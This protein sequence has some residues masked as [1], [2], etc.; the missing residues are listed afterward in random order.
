VTVG[1]RLVS[2]LRAS[3]IAS[4]NAVGGIEEQTSCPVLSWAASGA[5]W[6]TGWPDGPPQWPA[7]DVIGALGGTTALLG[8]LAGAFGGD[9]GALD[10]GA[11][12]TGRAAVR[13][14]ARRG[15]TSV[16][17]RSRILRAS[18]GWV[19][20]TLSRPCDLELLPALSAGEIPAEHV[21]DLAG[22]GMLDGAMADA[23]WGRLEAFTGSR[24]AGEL[25][26][27]A[28]LLGLPVALVAT[29][30]GDVL[31]WRISRLGEPASARPRSRPPRVVDFSAMWAGPLCAH[32]L[33]R[34]GA[35][36]VKVEHAGRPDA[37]RDGDP[38]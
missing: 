30:A 16:G 34:C 8:A 18:D 37:A 14:G 25:M 31:P 6:L 23:L 36:V 32:I 19:A 27:K 13:G 22:S 5:M 38:W 11:A 7:G 15:S 24:T 10:I 20:V 35:E 2:A 21:G 17:G 3:G 12:L 9:P 33:G 26:S 4:P 28:Q 1:E 29:P